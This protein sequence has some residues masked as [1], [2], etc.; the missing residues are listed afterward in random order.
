MSYLKT[1]I[2]RSEAL[3]RAVADLECVNCGRERNS[4]AA[5]A[6]LGKGMGIKASDARIAALCAELCHPMLDQSGAMTK[7]ERREFEALMIART[8]IRLIER[9]ALRFDAAKLNEEPEAVMSVLV[10][11]VEGGVLVVDTKRFREG[12]GLL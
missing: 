12:R 7:E 11:L 10:G 3:R 6:N 4:Q 2:F 9:G 8:L 1:P 5:H